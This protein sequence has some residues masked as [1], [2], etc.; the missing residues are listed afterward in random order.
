MRA[1]A[2]VFLVSA[3]TG[4][5]VVSA[6]SAEI[7]TQESLDFG[8][9]ALN[10]SRI[11]RLTVTNRGRVAKTVELSATPPFF[12]P[13]SIDVPGGSEVEVELTFRP[14][15]EGAASGT[16]SVDGVVVALSGTGVRP[17][18][19]DAGGPC[20]SVRF[21][22]ETLSCV[23]TNVADGTACEDEL[24]CLERGVCQAGACLG[25]AARCDDRDACTSDSCAVGRGCQHSTM[26]CAGSSNPCQA[27]SCDPVRGCGLTPVQDGTP[28]GS[29]SCELAN[30][31]LAGACR[32]VVPPDGFTCSPESACRGEG[33][34][35][36]KA[37]V[38]PAER[39]LTP[40]W[41]VRPTT[42]N[43]RFEG[44]V[45]EQGN[46]YWVECQTTAGR[47]GGAPVPNVPVSHHACT[48]VSR[49]QDGLERF[50][51]EVSGPGVLQIP[52]RAAQ[53]VTHGLFVFVVSRDELAAVDT[54][55]GA[56]VWQ[57]TI[58]AGGAVHQLAADGAGELWAAAEDTG[59]TAGWVLLK[60]VARTGTSRLVVSLDD[61]PTAMLAHDAG[62]VFV[63]KSSL[64]K[65]SSPP[66]LLSRYDGTGQQRFSV[67][68]GARTLVMVL[69][70]RLVLSDD[71][72]RSALD[73][74]ELEPGN[75]SSDYLGLVGVSP[76]RLGDRMRLIRPSVTGLPP[77]MPGISLETADP[78]GGRQH[79]FT[80]RADRASSPFLTAG[81]EALF[82]SV[83]SSVET[84]V[85]QV[86]RLGVPL[87][88]CAL[89][90]VTTTGA[91]VPLDLGVHQAFNGRFLLLEAAWGSC[92]S[93]LGLE[94]RANVPELVAYDLLRPGP[95]LAAH[96][97]V[98]P[99]GTPGNSGRA[100]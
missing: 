99:R 9:T 3:C 1:F 80:T 77:T 18:T 57:R 67:P 7:A 73:G 31:C 62:D 90:D 69:G 28:C 41:T 48:V 17:L 33:T 34:C 72:V 53:L 25:Q 37:C 59:I 56:L 94:D 95:G 52:Q 47:T 68:I 85:H 70:E 74:A 51:V 19:C 44:V 4:P 91:Q 60:V 61:E 96:G 5:A 54:R 36:N 14:T 79:P 63:V 89:V 42:P 66:T 23:T 65:P 11:K 83:Q 98:G 58:N 92:A 15:V 64:T 87:M 27:P 76:G 40:K 32:A 81:G 55:T 49:T 78:G 43:F 21:D 29:V 8:P 50:R 30:I 100:R 6:G 38:R 22:P 46:F 20:A 97:W 26:Q 71:S 24:A 10:F 35:Q 39:A 16:V 82:T 88:S 2:L 75:L 86:H 93:C 13:P 45:D 84:R 12:S